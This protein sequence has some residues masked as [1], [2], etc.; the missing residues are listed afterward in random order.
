MIPA[1]EGAAAEVPPTPYVE[2][3]VHGLDPSHLDFFSRQR[4]QALQTR[5]LILPSPGEGASSGGVIVWTPMLEG[6]VVAVASER[7]E[8]FKAVGSLVELARIHGGVVPMGSIST[9][10]VQE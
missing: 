5:F 3:T 4:S 8:I 9:G 1:K 2:E 7:L 6:R 10:Q